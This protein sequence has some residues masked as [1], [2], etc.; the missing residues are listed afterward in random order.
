[1][2]PVPILG[3]TVGGIVGSVGG[4]LIGGVAGI[5]L[6]KILEVYEKAKESKIKK[7]SV[8]PQLIANISPSSELV[9]SLMTLTYES[10]EQEQIAHA[11]QEAITPKS[12]TNSLYPSLDEFMNENSNITPENY[13]KTKEITAELFNDD[14]SIE[15]FVLTPM[16]DS[17]SPEEFASTTDLLV[18]RWPN[19]TNKPWESDEE[20]VLNIDDLNINNE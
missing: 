5:A 10:K 11:V 12:S 16:P 19:G 8:I 2:I 3:P 7:M 20:T 6:S 15:Y 13:Q 9:N 1:M 17:N 18:L 4:K 14:D